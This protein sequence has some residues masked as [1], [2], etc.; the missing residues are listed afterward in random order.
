MVVEEGS[1]GG[2]RARAKSGQ[3]LGDQDDF[4]FELDLDDE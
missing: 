2:G 4:A 1:E 3:S